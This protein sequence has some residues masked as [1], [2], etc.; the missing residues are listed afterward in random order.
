[1]LP[2]T[3]IIRCRDMK[4]KQHHRSCENSTLG[5]RQPITSTKQR[6]CT[7][8]PQQSLALISKLFPKLYSLTTTTITTTNAMATTVNF[9]CF[10]CQFFQSRPVKFHALGMRLTNLRSISGSHT[11]GWNLTHSHHTWNFVSSAVED[12]QKLLSPD[13]FPGL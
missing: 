13:A 3:F 12:I 9:F 7:N 6:L 4:A 8:R 2:N 10:I 11:Y 5:L 1:M